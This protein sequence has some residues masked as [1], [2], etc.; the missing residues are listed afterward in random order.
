MHSNDMGY[1]INK[2]SDNLMRISNELPKNTLFVVASTFG[3]SE[4]HTHF[5]CVDNIDHCRGMLIFYSKE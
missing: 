1:I 5:S 2:I 3:F 4:D